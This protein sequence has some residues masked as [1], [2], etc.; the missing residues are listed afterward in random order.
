MDNKESIK[1]KI[2]KLLAL[3]RDEGASEAEAAFAFKKA[4]EL[5][6]TYNLDL[7]DIKQVNADEILH[8]KL[9]EAMRDEWIK[10]LYT[11]TS[12]LYFC[13]YF[14][15]TKRVVDNMYK[16]SNKVVHHIIGRDHNI[17]ITKSMVT[18]FVDTIKRM[19][20]SHIAPLPGDGR[21]LNK[22]RRNY[23]LGIA[24][25]L[26]ERIIELWAASV[27]HDPSDKVENQNKN[28]PALYKTELQLC[29]DRLK[30]DGIRLS[31]RRSGSS[32]TAGAAYN[33]GKRDGNNVNLSGQITGGR[34]SRHL[35]SN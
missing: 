23:E 7:S 27:R 24:H 5:L 13:K 14:Y 4:H 9:I 17:E 2:Q 10:T 31:S 19:G 28:L 32:I 1:S 21:Q 18:Y 20:E 22:I 30:K 26:R 8:E 12:K 3:S 35:L 16:E 15:G 11:A 29:E 6:A 34:A 25:R 33:N